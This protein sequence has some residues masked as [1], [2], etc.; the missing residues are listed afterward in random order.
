MCPVT[1]TDLLRFVDKFVAVS[2]SPDTGV[3][4]MAGKLTL[5]EDG[6]FLDF[7]DNCVYAPYA[8]ILLVVQI[9]DQ[10]M[11]KFEDQFGKTGGKG[12]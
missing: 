11:A 7:Q 12:S 5:G 4:R 2:L 10:D 3:T 8:T 6:V 9:K 1:K